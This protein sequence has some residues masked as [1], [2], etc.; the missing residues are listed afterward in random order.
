VQYETQGLKDMSVN[1]KHVIMNLSHYMTK[2]AILV[3]LFYFIL[4]NGTLLY[5]L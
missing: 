2:L 5:V 3:F 1:V 4:F